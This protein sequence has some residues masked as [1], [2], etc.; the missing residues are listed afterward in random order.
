MIV[1]IGFIATRHVIGI[2]FEIPP[3]IPPLWL[4]AVA[5]SSVNSS[6]VSD[7]SREHPSKPIPI[8]NPLAAGMLIIADASIAESLPA[9]GSPHPAGTPSMRH[10]MTPPTVSRRALTRAISASVCR[11]VG[12]AMAPMR[13]MRDVMVMPRVSSSCRAKAPAATLTAV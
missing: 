5:N 1:A 3:W 12:S 2:P 9:R 11:G 7:P 8:S 13:L 6:M 4:V 10:S